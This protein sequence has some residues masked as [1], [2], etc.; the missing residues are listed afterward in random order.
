MNNE[1]EIIR[2]AKE[3]L[4]QYA[5]DNGAIKIGRCRTQEKDYNNCVMTLKATGY[6]DNPEEIAEYTRKMT[7]KE[8]LKSFNKLY[9]VWDTLKEFNYTSIEIYKSG[10]N[11]PKRILI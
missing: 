4:R 1:K 8:V 9:A 3:L 10:D 5:K 11:L 2:K 7:A 6:R